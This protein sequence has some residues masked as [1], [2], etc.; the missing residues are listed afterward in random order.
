M[1]NYFFIGIGG[2]G[3]SALAQFLVWQGHRVSGSDRGLDEP[4]RARLYGQLRSQGIALYPQD[5]SGVRAEHPDALVVSTAIEEGNPDLLAAPECPV[6]HRA[7][8]LA[9]AVAATGLPLVGIAGSCG[10]TS[11]TGWTASALRAAGHGVIMIDGGYVLDF[12]DDTHP[13]NFHADEKAD[14]VVA[15]IDESDH[16]IRE[17]SPDFSAVLNIGD[18][19]YGQEE[20]RNVF[21]AF[22]SRTRSAAVLPEAL[23]SMG[24]SLP[25]SLALRSFPDQVPGYSAS[26]AGISFTAPDGHTVHTTQSGRHSAWNGSAV[27][28]LLRAA[29]PSAAPE[30]LCSALGAFRGVRQRF[31]V[32]AGAS[33]GHPAIVNDY[34]HNP[35]K[36][37][38]AVATARERFGGGALGIVFQPHGFGPLG[39]IR[40][41][42]EEQLRKVLVPGDLFLMLPVFYAGGTSSFKPTSQ[43][44][45]AQYAAAGLPVRFTGTRDEAAALLASR[46]GLAAW[47]V[48][49]GRDA[50]LRTWSIELASG[51][52][53]TMK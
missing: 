53:A 33:A 9:D 32:I 30:A 22:L 41:A 19:H 21:T 16:S 28:E 27:L 29:L 48:L 24:A 7:K 3:M 40:Q 42:L 18:D 52:T 23:A 12:E 6:I 49:G 1:S 39:F 10:K 20:L 17:F 25:A 43:E 5:G 13:G 44:V 4:A 47:L 36:I 14:F 26:A 46:N 51:K 50:S 31:E 34:A 35:E 15:E 38:A 11:V 8:A 37:A 45:A 2:I